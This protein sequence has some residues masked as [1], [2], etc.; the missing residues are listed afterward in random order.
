MDTAPKKRKLEGLSHFKDSL[1]RA[2]VCLRAS[3]TDRILTSAQ[4]P[5]IQEL[6]DKQDNANFL[7]LSRDNINHPISDL[8]QLGS[9][10]VLTYIEQIRDDHIA[11]EIAWVNTDSPFSIWLNPEDLKASQHFHNLAVLTC[12]CDGTDLTKTLPWASYQVSSTKK[13]LQD[14]QSWLKSQLKKL[15]CSSRRFKVLSDSLGKTGT[16]FSS[17]KELN[18][19]SDGATLTMTIS[20]S[21]KKGPASTEEIIINTLK[22]TASHCITVSLGDSDQVQLSI[23]INDHEIELKAF[24]LLRDVTKKPQSQ[25]SKVG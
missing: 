8:D 2:L 18:L 14:L 10:Q 7:I 19:G 13:D 3:L 1:R 9:E 6:D 23:P 15:S 25:P 4:A 17:I 22:E 11:A 20:G 12:T 21:I 24:F 16:L 5:L